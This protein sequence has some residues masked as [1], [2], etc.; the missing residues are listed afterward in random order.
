MLFE[1]VI[2][3]LFR[4]LPSEKLNKEKK[5]MRELLAQKRRL[6]TKDQIQEQSSLLLSYLEQLPAFRDSKTV[7]IYYPAHNEVDVLQLIKRYKREKTFLFPVVKRRNMVACP[8]EGND[9]MHRGKYNIPEPTT[10]PYTGKIDLVVVPGVGFDERGNR[11][12]RGGGY[13]DVFLNR[14]SKDTVLVG[15]GYDFQLVDEVP[16]NRRDKRMNYIITPNVGVIKAKRD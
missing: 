13:Y 11:L 4:L 1:S 12:G 7:M 2:L 15:V 6:M 10:D 3:D 16:V 5:S 8:Y 9:K 14:V